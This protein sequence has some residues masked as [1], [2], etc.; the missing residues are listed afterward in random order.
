MS[1]LKLDLGE[2]RVESFEAVA[3]DSGQ[4]TVFG[5]ITAPDDGCV[6]SE[7]PPA[8]G[9]NGDTYCGACEYSGEYSNCYN[10]CYA[11]TCRSCPATCG[12]TC[13]GTCGN[14]CGEYSCECPS[15]GASYCE[16]CSVAIC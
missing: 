15:I 7:Y 14:S 10:T 13:F 5:H 3:R 6:A 8:C 12:F 16:T 4:G 11:A 1:K 9:S 2:L